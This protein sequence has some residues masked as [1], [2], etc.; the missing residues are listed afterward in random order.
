[1][2]VYPPPINQ[3][4]LSIFNTIDFTDSSGDSITREFAD[5]NYLKF[6]IA[7]GTENLFNTNLTGILDVTGN[8]LINGS[9][10]NGITFTDGSRLTT[11]NISGN[12]SGNAYPTHYTWYSN[13]TY[14][15]LDGNLGGSLFTFGNV[16][17]PITYGRTNN[18]GFYTEGMGSYFDWYIAPKNSLPNFRSN[19]TNNGVGNVTVV[20]FTG[21][22]AIGQL[23]FNN[24]LGVAIAFGKG[25]Y[26]GVSASD[27]V[28]GNQYVDY[29]TAYN[30]L[31]IHGSANIGNVFGRHTEFTWDPVGNVLVNPSYTSCVCQLTGNMTAGFIQQ[32]ILTIVPQV[33]RI[34]T[35][36][37]PSMP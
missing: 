33:P 19:N 6:P 32:M 29:T 36:Q 25:V 14:N 21:D 11:A 12:I 9:N 3:E 13:E 4:P 31:T 34:P 27:G 26:G 28:V 2:S 16:T 18:D 20:A 17:A 1:M 15:T 5:K 10:T 7:Q 24:N 23:E 30:Y 8:I 37:T 22:G 35:V